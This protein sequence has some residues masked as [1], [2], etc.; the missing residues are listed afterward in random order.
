MACFAAMTLPFILA[1]S[2]TDYCKS[3]STMAWFLKSLSFAQHV[4]KVSTELFP[5]AGAWKGQDLI[6]AK[7]IILTCKSHEQSAAQP[8]PGA[9]GLAVAALGSCSALEKAAAA[10]QAEDHG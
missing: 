5:I 9:I 10:P 8:S 7:Q 4:K 2:A 3:C 6:N 1:S